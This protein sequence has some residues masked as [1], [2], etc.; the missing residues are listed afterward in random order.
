[1]KHQLFLH[2]RWEIREV[3]IFPCNECKKKVLSL[4]TF[5]ERIRFINLVT[6]DTSGE[7]FPYAEAILH[8]AWS[9][10]TLL[11]ST[12]WTPVIHASR[13]PKR[14]PDQANYPVIEG[15]GMSH[16]SKAIRNPQGISTGSS[17]CL[18]LC[19]YSWDSLLRDCDSCCTGCT[20]VACESRQDTGVIVLSDV[21]ICTDSA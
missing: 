20:L 15:P 13:E 10:V 14:P 21:W 6:T 7:I 8:I 5:S 16:G 18:I 17:C 3:E 1:M 2:Y 12:H 9:L 19:L 11:T 4:F